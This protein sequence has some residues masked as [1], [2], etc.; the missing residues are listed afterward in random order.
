MPCVTH[1]TPT[2]SSSCVTGKDQLDLAVETQTALVLVEELWVERPCMLSL[3]PDG[4]GARDDE[5]VPTFGIVVAA[6]YFD[7][8]TAVQCLT[9]GAVEHYLPSHVADL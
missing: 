3:H 4:S 9:G 8:A 2:C 7:G 1:R 5:R 6:E